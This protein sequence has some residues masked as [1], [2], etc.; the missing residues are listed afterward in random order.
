MFYLIQSRPAR[1]FGYGVAGALLLAACGS[2]EP[3]VEH[4][5]LRA[6]DGGV[7]GGATTSTSGG[8]TTG[9]GGQATGSGGLGTA[10]ASTTGS[11]GSP[12]AGGSSGSTGMGGGTGTGGGVVG[13]AGSCGGNFT[14]A[15]VKDCTTESEC[16]LATHN[17]CCGN[18]MVAIRNGTNATFTAAE[19]A[20]QSCVPGCGLRGCF[21]ADTAEDGKQAGSVGQAI[22]AQCQNKRCTS[23]VGTNPASCATNTDCGAGRLCVAFVSNIGP[24][25]STKRECRD[26]AC[27][28]AALACGC[29]SSTC[30]GAGF[31]FCGVSGSQLTCDDG[32]Q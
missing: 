3:T 11:G 18:V 24:M 14:N 27:G 21:H 2:S 20:F 5:I 30:T 26:N 15:L 29:A 23:V 8:N 10:G 6:G 22:V 32:R 16:V 17:D 4:D 19:Q 31:P 7:G 28:A 1:S 13:D 25:T 9:S 12:S